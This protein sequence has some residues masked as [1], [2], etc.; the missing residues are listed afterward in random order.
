MA[1]AARRDR[2][3]GRDDLHLVS[4]DA[5]FCQ[6]VPCGPVAAQVE[7]LHQ[8]HATARRWCDSGRWIRRIPTPTGPA[9]SDLVV[10]C[11][12]GQRT[13]S[14]FEFLGAEAPDVP[15]PEQCTTHPEVDQDSPFSRIPYHSQIEFRLTDQAMGGTTSSRPVRP[16]PPRGSGST[17]RRCCPTD[18]GNR[19]RWPSPATS[20]ALRCMPAPAALR[21]PSW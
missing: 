18:A 20:W 12:F 6:A 8:G 10:T 13:A 5:T 16:A 11:V 3:G 14:A 1:Y 4:T 9:G 21:A 19:R 2:G 7:V 15:G 17:G